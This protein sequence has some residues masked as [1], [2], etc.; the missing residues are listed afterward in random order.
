VEDAPAPTVGARDV[1]IDVHAA[2]VNPVDCKI[3]AGSQR[4]VIRYRLPHVLGLDVS[5]VVAQVGPRVTRFSVGDEVYASPTHRRSGTYAELTSVDERQ[6]ARKPR[7]IDH[8]QA[9][10]IPLAGLTAWCAL[11]VAGRIA[12]GERV[13][14][15]AGAGGVGTLAIQIAR[16]FGAEIATTC[17]AHNESLVRELGATQVIDHRAQ[18]FEDAVSGLDLVLDGVGGEVKRRSLAALRRGGRLVSIVADIPESVKRHGPLLGVTR[19]MLELAR[20]KIAA[21]LRHGVRATNVL[22]PSDGAMLER[23]TEL[24]E[25]G[26]IRPVVDRVLPLADIVEAHRYSETGRA[27]G[28]I[29]IAVR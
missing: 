4:A 7:N 10:G 21:R 12:R 16:H 22:R 6:V 15:H 27:R 20:F 24:I 17:G 23:L 2:S 14:I 11:V 13:L 3:R 26:A 19:A 25:Q 28:K 9:A 29:I 8:Q 1:L 5:G 18:P